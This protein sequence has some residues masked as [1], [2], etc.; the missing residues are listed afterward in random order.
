MLLTV[1]QPQI[2][3]SKI[4]YNVPHCANGYVKE[5][6]KEKKTTIFTKY[7]GSKIPV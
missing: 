1:M 5:K 6:E 2:Q 7:H 3:A 4:L